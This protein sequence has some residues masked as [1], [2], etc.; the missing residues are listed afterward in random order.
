[1]KY[2]ATCPG[3]GIRFPRSF[4]FKWLPHVRRHCTA[5]GC[6]YRANSVW[7][8]T[9]SSLLGVSWAAIGCLAIFRAISWGMAA[10]LTLAVGL[11][12]YALFPYVTPFDLL[13]EKSDRKDTA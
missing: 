5:C 9:G 3:C 12:G 4:F 2:R 8:W 6:T 10:V 7:E 11:T 13:E 1:M